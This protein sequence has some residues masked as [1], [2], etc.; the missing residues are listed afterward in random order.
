MY[1]YMY[2]CICIYVCVYTYIYIYIYMFILFSCCVGSKY[3]CC[4]LKL[5]CWTYLR[6]HERV[7]P[8][9]QFY[10]LNISLTIDSPLTVAS[11]IEECCYYTCYVILCLT[12]TLILL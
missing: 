11:K 3:F 10:A 8:H 12:L 9:L 6:R 5:L 2:V 4:C 1:M 7:N